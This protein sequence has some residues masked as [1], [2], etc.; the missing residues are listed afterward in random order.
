MTEAIRVILGAYKKLLLTAGGGAIDFEAIK[1]ARQKSSTKKPA[2]YGSEA[3]AVEDLMVRVSKL[4]QARAGALEGR[5]QFLDSPNDSSHPVVKANRSIVL[6]SEGVPA[7]E[8]A[9]LLGITEDSVTRIRRQAGREPKLGERRPDTPF[10]E[11]ASSTMRRL[12]V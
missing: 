10:T 12:D 4:V 5:P 1:I 7:V 11:P 6:E 2:D 8:V 3:V 9:F